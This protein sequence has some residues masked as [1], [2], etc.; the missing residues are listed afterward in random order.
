M[1]DANKGDKPKFDS[2]SKGPKNTFDKGKSSAP[3]N[4]PS[5]NSKGKNRVQR[6]EIEVGIVTFIRIMVTIQNS[7]ICYTLGDILSF[8]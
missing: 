4:M 7:V 5:F 6:T 8:L 3:N 1:V 2:R